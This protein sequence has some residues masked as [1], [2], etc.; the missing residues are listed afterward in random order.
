MPSFARHE[1][2]HPR[3]GWLK[4]AYDFIKR[5]P[6]LF[7]KENAHV[8]LGVGKN[9]ARSMKQWS[10][11]F[12]LSYETEA[13]KGK[14][15]CSTD[16]GDRVLSEKGLDPYMEKIETLWL[17]HWQLLKEPCLFT[18]WDYVFNYY[19]GQRIDLSYLLIEIKTFLSQEYPKFKVADSSLKSDM[20]CLI[21]MYTT[22]NG[23]SFSEDSI[24]SPFSR[25]ELIEVDDRNTFQFSYGN[26]MSLPDKI[27]AACCL[28]Y[29]KLYGANTKSFPLDE[30]SYAPRS[31]GRVFKVSSM[32]IEESIDN[33]QQEGYPLKL[34]NTA[35]VLN[36]S[37]YEEPQR[38]AAS[39]VQEC[40][41]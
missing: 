18:F 6:A 10:L 3:Y 21:R 32:L 28:D 1:S 2:F 26:Q 14:N 36:I 22:K 39:L 41:N 24:D 37:F 31:P 34:S 5:D 4:K 27:L 16:F 13:E 25:L 35:G 40:Y 33:L 23:S 8:V 15:L 30:L 9:M 38:L 19:N 20:S 29:I 17:L 11:A 7:Q 12:K